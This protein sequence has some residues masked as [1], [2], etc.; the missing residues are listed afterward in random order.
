MFNIVENLVE[1]IGMFRSKKYLEE[2]A[3]ENFKVGM[4]QIFW[5]VVYEEKQYD[6]R[7]NERMGNILNGCHITSDK[8]C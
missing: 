6:G 2:N 5:L 1:Y 3:F 4:K 7:I 8:R